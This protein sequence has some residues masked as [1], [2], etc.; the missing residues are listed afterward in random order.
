MEP[1]KEAGVYLN[2]SGEGELDKGDYGVLDIERKVPAVPLKTGRSTAAVM[3]GSGRGCSK[4]TLSSE[5]KRQKYREIFP[6]TNSF[7][8]IVR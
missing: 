2:R 7:I 5:A 1:E 4:Q 6:R 3:E 8:R